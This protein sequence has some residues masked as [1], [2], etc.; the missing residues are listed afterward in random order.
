MNNY[1]YSG[2]SV[3]VITIILVIWCVIKIIDVNVIELLG[4]V[5]PNARQ[6]AHTHAYT[7]R[8][9]ARTNKF[10]NEVILIK[11]VFT[12]SYCYYCCRVSLEIRA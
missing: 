4:S 6:P 9:L 8:F 5:V 10:R 3:I 7:A 1:Y 11:S 2:K 12:I